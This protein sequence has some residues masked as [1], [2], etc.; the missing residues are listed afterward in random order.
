MKVRKLLRLVTATM[1]LVAVIAVDS[2]RQVYACILYPHSW[3]LRDVVHR[4]HSAG[5][6]PNS[7]QALSLKRHVPK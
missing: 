4:R 1:L 5:G 6:L 3:Q 7:R 2:E